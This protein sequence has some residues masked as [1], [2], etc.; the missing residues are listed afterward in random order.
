MNNIKRVIGEL[1]SGEYDSAYFPNL[2]Y[3][4]DQ[5]N[6][7]ELDIILVRN[8]AG[9]RDHHCFGQTNQSWRKQIADGADG[10]FPLETLPAHVRDLARELYYDRAA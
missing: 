4:M 2:I 3:D 1:A 10:I 9:L 7:E 8:A 6:D 5:L